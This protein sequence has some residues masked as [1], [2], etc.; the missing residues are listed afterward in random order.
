MDVKLTSAHRD[1]KTSLVVQCTTP[2]ILFPVHGGFF[3]NCV[4][5]GKGSPGTAVKLLPCDHEVMGSSSRN[6]LLHK[7]RKRLHT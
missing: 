5:L 1:D 4:L 7:G 6:N 2:M 3:P